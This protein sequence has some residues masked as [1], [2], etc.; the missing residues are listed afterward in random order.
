ML[1]IPRA[2]VVVNRLNERDHC[3]VA[4]YTDVYSEKCHKIKTF[5]RLHLLVPF[6][7]NL[8]ETSRVVA[9]RQVI[10]QIVLNHLQNSLVLSPFLK[11]MI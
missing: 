4:V 9:G 7:R 2:Y 6:P 10:I 5:K 1:N 3:S 8:V 11:V